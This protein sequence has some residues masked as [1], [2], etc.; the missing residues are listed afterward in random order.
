MS[1][2]HLSIPLV[3][4]AQR[5]LL[6]ATDGPDHL[7]VVGVLA[8][9]SL[10]ALAFFGAGVLSLSRW[11]HLR[12]ATTDRFR[13]SLDGPI[14]VGGSARPASDSD[15]FQAAVSGTDC[16]V[17]EV[18]AQRYD[19]SSKGGGSWVTDEFRTTR[20][21]FVVDSPAGAIRVEPDGADLVLD[22]S[23][24]DKLG[25]GEEATGRTAAFFDAVGIDRTTG[26]VDVGIAEVDYG[27]EYRV[28]E[29]RVDVGEDIY[30]AGTALTNDPTV[31]GFDGPD[32]VIRAP[33]DRS[34]SERLF[35]HP[36]VIGD[37]GEQAVRQHFFRRG[38]MFAGFGVLFAVVWAAALSVYM[39]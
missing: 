21:P 39:A 13:A 25:G 11:R 20:R 31:G 16:L 15:S 2:L 22:E 23:I 7:L 32:A 24:V 17:C 10:G 5:P 30:V 9:C 14:E 28:R 33:T 34:L 4:S 6:L 12:K 1:A 26:S 29:G 18:K 38:L 36:F 8:I 35:G 3:A 19:S 27:T 37:E